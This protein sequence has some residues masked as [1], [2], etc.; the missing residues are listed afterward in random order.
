MLGDEARGEEW[1]RGFD[2]GRRNNGLLEE[3][4]SDTRDACRKEVGSAEGSSADVKEWGKKYADDA[5]SFLFHPT[6]ALSHF[7]P[8]EK[9]K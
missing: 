7:R 4:D 9:E 2:G 6:F 5:F 8:E 1:L 3:C